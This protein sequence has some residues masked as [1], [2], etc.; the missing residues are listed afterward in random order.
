ML[1]LPVA[2]HCLLLV[3]ALLS[4]SKPF[5]NGRKNVNYVVDANYNLYAPN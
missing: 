3:T 5:F 1:P 2:G 4:L